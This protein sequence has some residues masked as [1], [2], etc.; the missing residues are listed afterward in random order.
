MDNALQKM[1]KYT[2]YRIGSLD[3]RERGMYNKYIYEKYGIEMSVC[4][5][6]KEEW[7][8]TGHDIREMGCFP[9]T[10]PNINFISDINNSDIIEIS[11]GE[12]GKINVDGLLNNNRKVIINCSTKPSF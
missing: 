9:E 10:A 7:G 12:M 8:K 4:S 11:D 2:A 1:L 3:I 6:D 5:M